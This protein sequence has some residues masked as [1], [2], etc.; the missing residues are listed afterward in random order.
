MQL[1]RAEE[2]N[3]RLYSMSA[4]ISIER[5]GYYEILEKTQKG[6]PD[7]TEWILWFLQC[8]ENAISTAETMIE[9]VMIKSKFWNQH[10]ATPLNARQRMMINTLFDSFFGKLSSSKWATMT[11]CSPDTALRDI[12]DLIDKNILSAQQGGGR[13]AHYELLLPMSE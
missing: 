8:L 1:A 13:N 11:K 12:Q 3:R 9:K 2:N 5:N 6:S 7:I 4:Q 10:V